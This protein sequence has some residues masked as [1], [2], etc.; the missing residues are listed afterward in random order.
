MT[1]QFRGGWIGGR[2]ISGE[3]EPFSSRNPASHFSIVATGN[4][5]S[6]AQVDEAV[7]AAKQAA[8]GWAQTPYNERKAIC[9]AI[10][11]FLDNWKERCAPVMTREMGKPL[12]EALGEAGSLL[13]KVRVSA[14]AQESLPSLQLPGAPGTTR[15]KAHGAIG[16]IGPYNY[17]V[18]LIH[19]HLIPALLAGNTVVYKPSEITPWTGE[20]YG[21]LLNQLDLPE[22]VV[23]WV[24]GGG[25]VGAALSAHPGLDGIAFTGSWATG[26]KILE[27]N[28]DQPGK[29]IAL[30]MGGRNAAVVL[31]DA[32]LE[33]TVHEIVIG[34]C[35]TAGQ[36]CTAT[37]RV[38]VHS[39]IADRFIA[40][41]VDALKRVEPGDP[42]DGDTL[43]GPLATEGAFLRYQSAM[44][45]LRS[46]GVQ[47]LLA[48][49]NGSGGGFVYPS[50]HVDKDIHPDV[51]RA[52]VREELFGPNIALEVI[53]GDEDALE[54]LSWSPYGLS[55]SIFTGSSARFAWWVENSRSGIFNWNR[56][57][58]NASGLLPFGGVGQSGNFRP[59]GAGS[60]LHNSY[61]VA[62][63]Q[64][65]HGAFDPDPRFGPLVRATFAQE[66]E[67]A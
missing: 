50:V 20:L 49:R 66:K 36:R 45:S 52:Y 38:L 6:E 8:P 46:N 55:Q 41:L 13:G 10:E 64:K 32:H 5:A 58:N 51:W 33:Q 65:E 26:R 7:Q 61:P 24:Q 4:G 14:I 35:L 56:S 59:A 31:E 30:E 34:A 40:L 11:Q 19:T 23:N 15:W 39:E 37:S 3:G 12:R 27:A 18:H 44:E 25:S 48:H 28:L 57:T 16:I 29:L 53:D 2:W 1:H 47:A 21:E 22:G 43:M 54:R 62:V 42:T 60:A 9:L 17:P 63:L 67:T